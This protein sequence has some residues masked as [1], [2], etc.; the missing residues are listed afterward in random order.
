MASRNTPEY[1]PPQDAERQLD[2]KRAPEELKLQPSRKVGGIRN[3]V[4]DKLKVAGAYAGITGASFLGGHIAAGKVD[5]MAR[6]AIEA[7]ADATSIEACEKNF[8]E[9]KKE[10]L[11]KIEEGHGKIM[12]KI[13]D[14]GPVKSTVKAMIEMMVDMLN[15]LQ[16]KLCKIPEAVK[17]ATEI[18]AAIARETT[19]AIAMLAIFL[20]LNALYKK[21]RKDL[22]Q[23]LRDA[24]DENAARADANAKAIQD[25]IKNLG[26]T[27]NANMDTLAAELQKLTTRVNALQSENNQLKGILPVKSASGRDAT[28]AISAEDVARLTAAELSEAAGV[29]APTAVQKTEIK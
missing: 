2:L 9:T 22:P 29:M 6:P 23:K 13:L 18:T 11:S 1:T 16:E 3:W 7:V 26:T 19:R 28:E 12:G 24:A 20:A 17:E 15:S 5:D 25:A 14:M 27:Q 8:D 4:R 21:I 10:W